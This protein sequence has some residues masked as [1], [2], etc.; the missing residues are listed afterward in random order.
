MIVDHG[1]STGF[2]V[3]AS[4][5]H[6]ILD[7]LTNGVSVGTFTQ[8]DTVYTQVFSNVTADQTIGAAFAID[9]F[10]LDVTSPYGSPSPAGSTTNDVNTL[11]NA[12]IG[13]SPQLEGL[14]TQYV[15]TGWTGTGDVPATGSGTQTTF[16]LTTHSSL[17]WLWQ[18]NYFLDL[19]T[20][21]SGSVDVANGFYDAN[22]NLTV[23]AT[24][25][26]GYHFVNWSGDATGTNPVLNLILASAKTITANFGLNPGGVRVTLEPGGAVTSGG[27]WRLTSGPD[28]GW[29]NSGQT[30][31]GLIPGPYTIAYS[32]EFG[33]VTPSN[34]AIVVASDT[35]LSAIGHYA[36]PEYVFIAGGT[37][38]MGIAGGS[39]GHTI[40]V[41]DFLMGPG[42]ITGGEYQAFVTATGGSMPTQP[43]PGS[44][45]P[46]V[47][48][49]WSNAIQYLNWRSDQEGLD[50][51]YAWA[52]SAWVIDLAADGYRLPTEAEWEYAARGGLPDSLYPW[53]NTISQA[54]AN[55]GITPIVQTTV[56]GSYL[57]NAYGLFDVAGNTWE[58]TH[59]WFA[60][61]LPDGV[62]D[63]TGPIGG[64]DRV[65]RGGSWASSETALQCASRS[66]GEPASTFSDLGFRWVRSAIAAPIHIIGIS[67]ETGGPGMHLLWLS[68]PGR[69]YRLEYTSDPNLGYQLLDSGLPA[70][71]PVNTFLDSGPAEPARIYR[72]WQ[73]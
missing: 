33:F 20:V 60:P 3:T 69:T 66:S 53:G 16:T 14:T 46:V 36:L 35:N 52:G 13:G 64:T 67:P 29:K 37:F 17:S 49:S 8:A 47:N 51:A 56:G 65:M 48:V 5:D 68:Q 26:P 55:Y 41:S 59:D 61:S 6:H 40:T 18:T 7:V 15:A 2:V 31:T 50:R 57:P 19:R 54:N 23:T 43:W 42:E 70:T 32:D 44:A 73:E 22:T 39:G 24:A 25:D 21:S 45:L 27:Q 10:T 11:V 71:P 4:V 58:W 63:P 9:R 28:T 12:S 38:E 30:V 34:A 72:V 1:G 62:T